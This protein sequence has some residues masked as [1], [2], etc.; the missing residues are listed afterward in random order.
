M[1]YISHDTISLLQVE[2]S[3]K[4]ERVVDHSVRS[5]WDKVASHEEIGNLLDDTEEE[6][7]ERHRL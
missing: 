6:N 1:Q 4:L 3:L 5:E 7:G 2:Q